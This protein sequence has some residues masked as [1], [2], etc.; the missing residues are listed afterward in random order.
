MSTPKKQKLLDAL[1]KEVTAPSLPPGEEHPSYKEWKLAAA[2]DYNLLV[3]VGNIPED[4]ESTLDNEGLSA[5]TSLVCEAKVR[6][7]N[8]VKKSDGNKMYLHSGACGSL[9]CTFVC[10]SFK[11]T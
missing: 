6:F 4:L 9:Y 10:S 5:I 1:E 7:A 8:R 2:D 3:S 11:G